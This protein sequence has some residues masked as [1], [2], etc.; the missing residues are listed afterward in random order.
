MDA[1]S[2]T[3]A[4]PIELGFCVRPPGVGVSIVGGPRY[5]LRQ[6]PEVP[7]GDRRVEKPLVKNQLVLKPKELA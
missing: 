6:A 1:A 5:L 4:Q 3:I 7:S 2:L